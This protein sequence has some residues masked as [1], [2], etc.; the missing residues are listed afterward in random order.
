MSRSCSAAAS[1]TPAEV[2]SPPLPSHRLASPRP[3][4]SLPAAPAPPLDL[5]FHQDVIVATL[6]SGSRGNCTYI[7]DQ[8]SGVLVDCGLSARQVLLRLEQVGLARARI[9]AVLVTH[10]HTDHVGGARVLSQR[11]RDR[12]GRPVPFFATR[13]T[14]SR[15]DARC[16]PGRFQP[17]VSGAPFRIGAMVVE[18]YSVPHDTV[19]PVA[20]LVGHRGVTVGVL[21]DLGR[22]TRL[23]ERQVSRMDVAVVEFNHDVQML[24]EG[25]YPWRLKQRVRG[26]HGHLSN[27]EAGA[28]IT[29][30]ASPRLAHLVLAHLSEE[31]NLPNLAHEAACRALHRAGRTRVEV[32]V[33]QQ[34]VPVGPM[35]VTAPAPVVAP[36]APRPRRPRATASGPH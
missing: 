35:R 31:N 25:S 14:A 20:Y 28:L 34:A 2:H 6:A 27:E 36:Q 3:P 23:V 29:T 17:V 16:S 12:Q 4:R 21:T 22:T 32:T 9:D 1:P 7:G 26:A 19:D 8:R 13:G 18:P 5:L 30:A 11:L 15:V 33:A 10:E 24:L